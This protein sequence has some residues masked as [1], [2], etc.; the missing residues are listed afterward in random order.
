MRMYVPYGAIVS[1]SPV[2]ATLTPQTNRPPT[3]ND[4]YASYIK[5]TSLNPLDG[6]EEHHCL[7][8]YIPIMERFSGSENWPK[9]AVIL[10]GIYLTNWLTIFSM[11]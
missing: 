9:K 6:P 10:P 11:R 3:Q 2:S 1:P 8:S 7:F 4:N 5:A